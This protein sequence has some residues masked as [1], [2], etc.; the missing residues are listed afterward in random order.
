[1]DF[2]LVPLD[3]V[4]RNSTE[5]YLVDTKNYE[6][7][8]TTVNISWDGKYGQTKMFL[9]NSHSLMKMEISLKM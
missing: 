6:K 1:M 3:E 7:T 5:F 9:L 2:K 4:E 8:P